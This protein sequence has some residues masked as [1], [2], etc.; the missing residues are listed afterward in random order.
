MGI[1]LFTFGDSDINDMSILAAIRNGRNTAHSLRTSL[2]V[3]LLILYVAG[4]SG[5][6]RLHQFFHSHDHLVAH[7][8]IQ[9]KDPCHRSI[10]HNEKDKG[11]GHHS[12]LIVTDKCEL[13]DLIFHTD[14]ILLSTNESPALQFFTIDS[15]FCTSDVPISG[16]LI[17]SSR[18]PPEA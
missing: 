5:I 16:Q 8:E 18:A 1:I 4:T 3:L 2:A 10:Y 12:H 17:H 6:E 11:C 7:S 14:Q 15:G 13:C 9:E